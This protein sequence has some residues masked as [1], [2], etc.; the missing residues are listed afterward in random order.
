MTIQWA[1]A[2]FFC[3][4]ALPTSITI[5]SSLSLSLSTY[6]RAKSLLLPHQNPEISVERPRE[7]EALPRSAVSF[8]R[9]GSS[10][11]VWDDRFLSGELNKINHEDHTEHKDDAD[12]KVKRISTSTGYRAGKVVV[13]AAAEGE[14][15]SP[16]VSACGF[17]G[18]FRKPSSA[19]H[20]SRKTPKG[21][22]R[23]R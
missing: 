1:S 2:D 6:T 14:P 18:A 4:G 20:K 9:Q 22:R 21:R 11:L 5:I 7:M 8:R 19:A 3:F 15:P 12:A 17:C 10:G 13:A 16:R 23:A